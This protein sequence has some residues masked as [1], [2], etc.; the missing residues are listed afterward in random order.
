VIPARWRPRLQPP[1]AP[2][3]RS[4]TFIPCA[5]MTVGTAVAGAL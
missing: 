5:P 4:S 2:Q 3:N 1:L